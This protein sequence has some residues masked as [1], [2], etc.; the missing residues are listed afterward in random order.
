MAKINLNQINDVEEYSD[1]THIRGFRKGVQVNVNDEDIRIKNGHP[2][3]SKGT[4]R[5]YRISLR[6]HEREQFKNRQE[7]KIKNNEERALS[8][9]TKITFSEEMGAE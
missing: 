4:T 7:R 1:S 8:E 6:Q 2:T 3:C 5:A 9:E